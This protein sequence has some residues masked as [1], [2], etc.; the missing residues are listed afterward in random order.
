MSI[1]SNPANG[2]TAVNAPHFHSHRLSPQLSPGERFHH[3]LVSHPSGCLY[4][5]G[6]MDENN[7]FVPVMYRFNGGGSREW[8]EVVPLGALSSQ[9]QQQQGQNPN[10]STQQQ[11]SHTSVVMPP[12]RYCHAMCLRDHPQMQK[13]IVYGGYTENLPSHHQ[14]PPSADGNAPP[15]QQVANDGAPIRLNDMWEYDLIQHRWAKIKAVGSASQQPPPLTS[16]SLEY[17]KLSDSLILFGGSDGTRY[18]NDVWQFMF[19]NN[20]WK[21]LKPKHNLVPIGRYGHSAVWKGKNE[22]VVFGGG[23]VNALNLNDTLTF[24]VKTKSWKQIKTIG[25]KPKTRNR[26]GACIQDGHMYIFGGAHS[27][28]EMLNDLWSL[29]MANNTWQKVNI[30][31]SVPVPRNGHAFSVIA[32]EKA[33]VLFG[34]DD[35]QNLLDDT[36]FILPPGVQ[37]QPL[38]PASGEVNKDVQQQ[39]R[40]PHS[41]PQAQYVQPMPQLQEVNVA[42]STPQ[43]SNQSTFQKFAQHHQPQQQM[44]PL[45]PASQQQQP[46]QQPLQHQPQQ[47]VST[48]STPKYAQQQNIPQSAL[49]AHAVAQQQQTQYAPQAQQP[50]QQQSQ[51]QQQQSQPQ[52]QATPVQ[53]AQQALQQQASPSPSQQYAN[54]QPQNQVPQLQQQV[55]PSSPTP[56][57]QM[58]HVATQQQQ[59]NYSP[60]QTPQHTPSTPQHAQQQQPQSQQQQAPSQLP[61]QNAQQPQQAPQQQYAQQQPQQQ[62]QA[63]PPRDNTPELRT[64]IQDLEKQVAAFTQTVQTLTQKNFLLQ[65]KLQKQAQIITAIQPLSLTQQKQLFIHN[66]KWYIPADKIQ[67]IDWKNPHHGSYS[68]VYRGEFND[69]EVAVKRIDMQRIAELHDCSIDRVKEIVLNEVFYMIKV[70]N[71]HVVKPFGVSFE[72]RYAMVVMEW[73]ITDLGNYI[74]SNTLNISAKVRMLVQIAQA[75]SAIHQEGI[76]HRDLKPRNIL[77]QENGIV[78]IIDFGIS[79]DDSSSSSL[80]RKNIQNNFLYVAP[81]LYVDVKPGAAQSKED[82][83]TKVSD[84]YAFGMIMYFI[85]T[86]QEPLKEIFTRFSAYPHKFLNYIVKEKVHPDTTVDSLLPQNCPPL[87]VDLVRKCSEHEPEKRTQSFEEILRLL[88]TPQ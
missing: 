27:Q 52:Q 67:S 19:S 79:R 80:V 3:Q 43:Y 53:P 30:E 73:C 60:Q 44:T 5:Y 2:S 77:I 61:Y 55:T 48:P 23:T 41:E 45:S 36:Y 72:D 86:G 8:E 51:P 42:P 71:Q 33:L 68:N 57:Q 16:H 35:G 54:A 58:A 81:E 75:M 85:L 14:S 83:F 62:Q 65:Q 46:Q 50:Q 87:L 21:R 37:L 66:R 88:T 1:K 13:L 29:N 47:Q 34:G 25:E 11:Q 10:G 39:Q 20:K 28:T 24:S 22:L 76:I 4:L 49:G 9:Q 82:P 59:Q 56:S 15:Q 18:L 31:G 38:Q 78:K 7:N 84:V 12:A 70:N 74:R 32:Q 6:G 17:H 69:E 64:K 40:Q 26:H 63:P